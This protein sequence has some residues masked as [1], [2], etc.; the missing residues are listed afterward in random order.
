V[1]RAKRRF[2]DTHR[3]F[4]SISAHAIHESILCEIEIPLHPLVDKIGVLPAAV[5][6][7]SAA[8]HRA[9]TSR[10]LVGFAVTIAD[11]GP[12]QRSGL[13]AAVTKQA[14]GTPARC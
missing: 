9:A 3:A 14:I 1:S 5:A 11:A 13:D 8:L 10:R 12:E 4:D 6:L 2:L 7:Y